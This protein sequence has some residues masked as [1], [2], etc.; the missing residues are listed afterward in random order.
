MPIGECEDGSIGA[1]KRQSAPILHI[2]AVR[3]I[4]F[5]NR[6]RTSYAAH[7]TR[8]LRTPVAAVK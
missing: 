5:R 8:H 4:V 6:E 2:A 1:V 7:A 3:A